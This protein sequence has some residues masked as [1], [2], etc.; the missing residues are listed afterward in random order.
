MDEE[1]NYWVKTKDVYLGK[2]IWITLEFSKWN[3]WGFKVVLRLRHCSAH[4]FGFDLFGYT[5]R[6]VAYYA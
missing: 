5:F 3:T 6:M 2:R 1:F 4:T